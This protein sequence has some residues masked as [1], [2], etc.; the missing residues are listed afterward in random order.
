MIHPNSLYYGDCLEIMQEFPDSCID[1]IY[2]DPPFN[3]K[4]N[5]NCFFPNPDSK[6]GESKTHLAQIM[7]FHDTWKWDELAYQRVKDL[8]NATAHPAHRAIKAFREV[9]GETGALAYLSYMAERLAAMKRILKPIGSVYLHCDSTMSHYLK[10]LMDSIFG[11]HNFQNDIAWKRTTSRGDG[12]RYGRISDSILYYATKGATW[13]NQYEEGGLVVG[14][15]QTIPLTGAGIAKGESGKPWEG[16]DPAE[17]GRGRHWSV[18]KT[19]TYAEWLDQNLIPG[20]LDIEGVHDRLDA[21]NEKGLIR[22]SKNGIP[23][24]FRPAEAANSGPKVNDIWTDIALEDSNEFIKDYPTRKPV[25]LVER[26]IQASLPKD[27]IVFDPFCGCGTTIEAA[28]NLNCNWI[29]IDISPYAINLIERHRMKGIALEVKGVPKDLLG[30]KRLARDNPFD[31]EKWAVCRIP[32]IAPNDKQ[33]G[34]GG[35]D[36]RGILLQ[37]PN[38]YDSKLVLAQVKGGKHHA[39]ALRDFLGVIDSNKAAMGVYITLSSVKSHN[40][41][42]A[43]GEKGKIKF[44]VTEFPRAQ[45]WSIENHFENLQPLMP[46]LADPYT[47]KKMLPWLF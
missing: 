43:I 31:F 1:L 4:S 19:G 41:H 2:L 11:A 26:I 28:H 14:G 17:S 10:I 20:Y 24:L 22:F 13:R 38:N 46:P 18:P 15:E 32:G 33:V 25:K 44:G 3:S 27:G 21:L 39:S 6:N 45:L 30:A 37:R 9:I 34:D 42:S 8:S 5:Y 7:A 23:R 47:G 29:G 12:N 40:A 16:Y 36:G 35:I